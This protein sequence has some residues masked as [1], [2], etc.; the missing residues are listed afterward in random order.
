MKQGLRM[1]NKLNSQAIYFYTSVFMILL[2]AFISLP[3]GTGDTAELV[4]S[5]QRMRECLNSGIL[6]NCTDMERFGLSPHLISI[7]LLSIFNDINSAITA[8]SLLN[9]LL[10][11]YLIYKLNAEYADRKYFLI[12]TI[13]FSPLTAYAVYSYTEMS[14]IVLSFILLMNIKNERYW[15]SILLGMFLSGY[16]ETAILIVLPLT[17][18]VI[19][20]NKNKL[21]S[22]DYLLIAS[23]VA[24]FLSV[25]VFN[26][27]KYDEFINSGYQT[28]GRVKE[29]N[30]QISNFLGIWLS[31]SGGII[32][33]FWISIILLLFINLKS[34]MK[35]HK[36]RKSLYLILFTIA[37]NA[38]LLTN[39][40][41]PY[42]WVTWGPRLF[43]PVV[44]L[45]LLSIIIIRGGTVISESKSL[46]ITHLLF[47]F[48]SSSA[49][50]GFLINSD[51]F[52]IWLTNVIFK[53]D[54]CPRLFIW[55]IERE[56]YINCFLNM[57]WNLNSLTFLTIKNYFNF[58]Y[59][60][61][62][63]INLY[64]F[65]VL[66]FTLSFILYFVKSITNYDNQ[67]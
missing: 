32:G 53:V 63:S 50:I 38:L 10:F 52:R 37:I 51:A 3:F 36:Y 13:V 31:P 44:V 8:W 25:Y 39:W 7:V 62:N 29:I 4:L 61:S 1:L 66:M 21:I 28:A 22:K 60:I 16:K 6:F 65:P 9:F 24:G 35:I 15:L 19:L 54:V 64:T 26:Y 33:F 43:M 57:S 18:A 45:G 59:Q 34:I 56:P 40:Y 46:H 48:L 27:F 67:K 23:P 58:L 12:G 2:I 5:S 20:S 30:L 49:L 17:L 14:F 11:A 55:E 42:G 47:S 41:A